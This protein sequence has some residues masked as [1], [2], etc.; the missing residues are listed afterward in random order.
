MTMAE[1][2][3][4]KENLEAEGDASDALGCQPNIH[5]LHHCY[6]P[7]YIHFPSMP[8]RIREGFPGGSADKN[9]PANTEDT[10]LIPSLGGFHMLQSNLVHVPQLLS[11][12]SR[13]W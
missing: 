2:T 5:P 13:A 12:R 1:G 8:H 6:D 7:S 4:S 11:L 10:A 3:M 9:L